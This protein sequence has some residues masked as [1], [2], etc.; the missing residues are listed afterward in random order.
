MSELLCATWA[1]KAALLTA[2][3]VA[4]AVALMG[5]LAIGA[6]PGPAACAP[7]ADGLALRVA[8]SGYFRRCH[9]R[10]TSRLHNKRGR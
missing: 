1:D 6:V 5:P 9:L 8:R 4:F 7:S 10:G 3:P 2:R